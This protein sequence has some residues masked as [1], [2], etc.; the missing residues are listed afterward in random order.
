MKTRL[1]IIISVKDRS[2]GETIRSLYD[3]MDFTA[4]ENIP[5]LMIFIDFLKAFDNVEWELKM[6]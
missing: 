1:D 3:I 4:K 5:G 6:S 2:I